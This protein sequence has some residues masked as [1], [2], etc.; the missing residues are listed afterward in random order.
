MWGRLLARVGVLFMSTGW[1]SLH[2]KIQDNPLWVSEPFTKGQA[3]VDLILIANHTDGFF[4]VRG[5]KIDIKR[6]QTGCSEI[7]LS[8]RWRWSRNK[9]RRFL[10]WLE[11][12]RQIKQQTLYKITS[13]ITILN[14][15]KYQDD[16]SKRQQKDNRRYT[17]NNENNENNISEPK[18]SG[19]KVPSTQVATKWQ[20]SGNQ[21]EG[22]VPLTDNQDPMGNWNKKSDN[23]DDM[24]AL[25]MDTREEIETDD[26]KAERET[27]ELNVKIRH[28]LKLFE[29]L[30]GIA[31]GTGKDMNFHVKAYRELLHSGWSHESILSAFIEIVGSPH[32]K[33]KKRERRIPRNEHCPVSPT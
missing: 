25:D 14:Y 6:G 26:V 17:N 2:R 23:D 12:E 11:N 4:F 9:V 33:E 24:V 30:R 10:L 28:N 21:V 16:T 1:I 22:S 20:P 32:W 8:K 27:K 31:W 3:W 13:I 5:V 19:S 18:V 15:G 29:P 7:T